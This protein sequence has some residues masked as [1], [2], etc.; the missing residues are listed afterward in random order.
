MP[1]PNFV[2]ELSHHD[3]VPVYHQ[4]EKAILEYIESGGLAVDDLIPPERD[5]CK[6]NKLSLSTVRKA[7]QNLVHK[8]YLY[9]IQ[10]KGTFV[11]NT[12]IRRKNIRYYSFVKRFRGETGRPEIRFIDL[13]KT[14]ADEHISRHLDIKS[15][16]DIYQLRRMIYF[17][18][19][20]VVYCV[21]CLPCKLFP[22]LDEFQPYYFERHAFY[23]F[24]EKEYGVTTIMNRDIYG[25]ESADKLLAEMLEVKKGHP[26]LLIEMQAITHKDKPYEYRVSHCRVDERKIRREY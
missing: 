12:S 1:Q 9:R 8:G 11:A 7:L 15:G 19:Q 2:F 20:P 10:G 25:A 17:D 5:I 16:Q 21:S 13:K 14:R 3:P 23:I 6:L 22:K 18:Q 24:V 4:L 26:L